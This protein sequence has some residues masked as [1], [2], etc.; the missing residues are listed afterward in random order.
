MRSAWIAGLLLAAATAAAAQETSDQST[1]KPPV[2]FVFNGYPSIRIGPLRVDAHTKWQADSRR[3]D[4]DL[5]DAGKTY[6]TELKRVGVAGRFTDR[7]EFEIERELRKNNPWR[8]VYINVQLAQAL[9]VRAGKMKMPFSYEELTG[10]TN[11]DFVYRTLLARIISPAREV[12]V[13]AHGRLLRRIVEYQAGW[14]RH[15]GENARLSEPFFLLPGEEP[16]A[17]DRSVAG[18]VVVEPFRH[19]PGPREIRR[20]YLGVAATTTKVPEG[21][22][23]FRGRSLFGTT[24]VDRVYVLGS[25]RR[26]GTEAVWMPGPVSVKTE[27][28]RSYEQRNHQGLL[29]EDLSDFTTTG[30]YVSGTW[31]LTGERKDGGVDAR[32]PLFEKGFGAIEVGTRYETISFESVLKQGIAF[33]NP[34]ADPFLANAEH[35]WT[36]GTNWYLN[37]WGKVVVNGIRESFDDAN[38][39]AIPGRK[40]GWAAVL[41]LQFVM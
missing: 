9:E 33:D 34:R 26:I 28:A 7:I 24:F 20:L 29:D 3:A 40:S 5:A 22:N 31:L 35:I 11:L 36:I 17:A 23:S 16:P 8:N 21:L 27:W 37:K 10:A 38:R 6:E 12:G 1:D 4:Q 13:M 15:D 25:R 2:R 30:W 32:K 39:T 18:R 19:A 14:F 41:R